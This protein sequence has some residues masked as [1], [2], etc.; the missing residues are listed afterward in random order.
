M[1]VA[2]P[3]PTLLSKKCKGR[4]TVVKAPPQ[5]IEGTKKTMNKISAKAKGKTKVAEEHQRRTRKRGDTSS[6]PICSLKSA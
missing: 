6:F 1:A 2:N 3:P 5:V 4:E